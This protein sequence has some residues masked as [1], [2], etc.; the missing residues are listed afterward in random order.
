MRTVITLAIGFWLGRQTYIKYDKQTALKQR[1][2]NQKP[3]EVL[4]GRKWLNQKR[5]ER[6]P[7]KNNRHINQSKKYKTW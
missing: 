6:N 2:A 1:R 7:G 5:G 3:L 4:F